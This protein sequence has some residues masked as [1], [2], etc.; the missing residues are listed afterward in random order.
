MVISSNWHIIGVHHF[1]LRGLLSFL[2]YSDNGA[3]KEL[4]SSCIVELEMSLDV[5]NGDMWLKL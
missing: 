4:A 3:P 2:F 1:L 5:A